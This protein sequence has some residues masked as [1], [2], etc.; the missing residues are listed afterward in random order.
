MC[1]A[2]VAVTA[3]NDDDDGTDLNRMT[4]AQFVQQ[5]AMNDMFEIETGNMATQKGTM[6]DVRDFGAMLESDHTTSSTELMTLASQ[7]NITPP[8]ALT[9]PM[10]QR[11]ETLNNLQGEEFDLQFAEMQVVSH[12]EAVNL[13]E[14]AE[15]ELNDADLRAF[16]QRTLPV[17]RMHLQHAT[18]LR[19]AVMN[20]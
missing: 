7:K 20:R 19:D 2:V 18:D 10:Q 8:T 9:G 6:Q 14:T 1:L 17:L 3:C 15:D 5:A 13:Y 12:Q 11:R 16:A 4:S